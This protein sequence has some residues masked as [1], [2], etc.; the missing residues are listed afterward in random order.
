M[1]VFVPDKKGIFGHYTAINQFSNVRELG[2]QAVQ[3]F[4][5]CVGF[6]FYVAGLLVGIIQG[7]ATSDNFISD[8]GQNP[9]DFSSL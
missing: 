5:N 4:I 6:V 8:R 1:G 3:A 9:K 2:T 7:S